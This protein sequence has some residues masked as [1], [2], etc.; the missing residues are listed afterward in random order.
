MPLLALGTY[1]A[2][3]SGGDS[4]LLR[5]QAASF[6]YLPFHTILWAAFLAICAWGIGLFARLDK[7]LSASRYWVL[8]PGIIGVIGVFLTRWL[9]QAP[10]WMVLYCAMPLQLVSVAFLLWRWLRIRN[11]F[12]GA[13]LALG[14]SIAVALANLLVSAA[15]GIPIWLIV[16]YAAI[17]GVG[18]AFPMI[19]LRFAIRSRVTWPRLL[20]GMAIG[21]L[22]PMAGLMAFFALIKQDLSNVLYLL[23]PLAAS[24]LPFTALVRWNA[25]AQAVATGVVV[26][27]VETATKEE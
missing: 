13:L 7:A 4:P 8:L 15:M 22:L 27:P 20:L 19:M 10:G 24:A 21:V 12:L 16:P 5:A 11:L 23:I 14:A 25:W 2:R 9:S 17:L 6:T 3:L 1:T 26:E 18:L